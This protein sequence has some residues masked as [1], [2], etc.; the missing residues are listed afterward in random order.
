M[1]DKHIWDYLLPRIGNPYGVAGLMGNLYAES[2]LNPVNLQNS[3]ER[4]LGMV[5]AA[6]TEAVDD[7]SYTN[8]VHD[9]AGYGLAQWTYHTR[10][11]ALL[12]SAQIQGKSIGDLDMQLDY[13]WRE[14]QAYTGVLLILQT[15]TTVRQASDIVLTGYERPRDQSEVVKARR[16]E[17]GQRFFD[18]YGGEEMAT[19]Y[20]KYICSTGTH[21]ISNSGGDEKGGTKGGKAG[22]QTGREWQLK[23][24]YSRP[25]T[26]VL[27]WPNINVGTLIA[28]LGIDAALNNKIGYDQYQRDTYWTQLK[29]V[30]YFPAKI[31][32]P[33]E[34]D[35]TAGVNANVHAA[36]YLLGIKAIQKIKATG[37]RST[38]MRSNY[39]KAGFQVLTDKKYLTGYQYLL[40]GD[41]LLYDN[42]HACTNVTAGKKVTYVYHDV[43]GNIA[44]YANGGDYAEPTYHLGDRTLKNGMTGDDVKEMQTDLIKCGF[45]CGRYGADGDFGDATEE[46]LRDFQRSYS[47]TVDGECGPETSAMLIRAVESIEKPVTDPIYVEIV[48]GNCYIRKGPSKET[49][50]ISVAHDGQRLPY[51]GLVDADTGWLEVEYKTGQFGW[52]SP[53]Y[54]R[55]TA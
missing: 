22:D 32:T 23:K 29:K 14:I 44:Q 40:P 37:I 47:L 41:I 20:K 17:Y 35:C 16:A 13:L 36:G 51:A 12:A 45:N 4:K 26:C 6:Y 30:G 50:A 5:D 53:K 21:Y 19:N 3:F 55:L 9:G 7:G 48:G 28:Q 43:I 42:H 1:N 10:K 27:R 25:W 15:A 24:W 49:E 52:I 2:G 46:A 33:C 54:G 8:F 31:V 11:A 39:K 18:M 34:E 38:N